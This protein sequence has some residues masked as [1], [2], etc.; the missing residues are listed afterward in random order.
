GPAPVSV[1]SAAI[2]MPGTIASARRHDVED[3]R[4]RQMCRR[5]VVTL[6]GVG[7]GL[8]FFVASPAARLLAG[9]AQAPASGGSRVTFPRGGII[10][11]ILKD[12]P[13]D[14]LTTGAT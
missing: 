2:P 7:G 6:L 14:A 9:A 11:T 13:P 12:L 8:G 3:P 10:R 4:S 1:A 5:R